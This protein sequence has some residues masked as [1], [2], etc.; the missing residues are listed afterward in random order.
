MGSVYCLHPIY[1]TKCILVKVVSCFHANCT[2]EIP[3]V[4]YGTEIIMDLISYVINS[5]GSLLH[6]N[7]VPPAIQTD[8]KMVLQLP[9]AVKGH[10]PAMLP[11]DEIQVESVRM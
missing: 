7:D 5:A 8:G 2:G 10:Y 9:R 4:Y 1:I 3:D 6:C 11:V